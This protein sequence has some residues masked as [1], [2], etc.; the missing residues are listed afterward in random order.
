MGAITKGGVGKKLVSFRKTTFFSNKITKNYFTS[1]YYGAV[2]IEF[3]P[4]FYNSFPHIGRKKFSI[5]KTKDR[6]AV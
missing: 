3:Q 4:F 2:S 6:T 1:S 5:M